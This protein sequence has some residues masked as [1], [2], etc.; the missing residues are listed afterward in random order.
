MGLKHPTLSRRHT[1]G[2]TL[3]EIMAV[4]LIILILAGLILSMAGNATREAD[5]ANTEALLTRIGGALE[6]YKAESGAY[7][8]QPLVATSLDFDYKPNEVK[9]TNFLDA[10]GNTIQ[11]SFNSASNFTYRIWST[12]PDGKTGDANFRL[13][14]ISPE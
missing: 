11:Y 9:G 13:D 2:F 3:V 12:G 14:D 7:P 6:T 10:W 5:I 4:V 1:A 8:S